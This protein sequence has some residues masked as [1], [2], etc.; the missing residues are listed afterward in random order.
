M[1]LRYILIIAVILFIQQNVQ[2]QRCS[3][4]TE[5]KCFWDGA[6]IPKELMCDG[7]IDCAK[8]EDETEW[9][10]GC[11][12]CSA[13]G[14]FHCHKESGQVCISRDYMCDDYSDCLH[15]E[16]E[17]YEFAKCPKKCKA[18]LEKAALVGRPSCRRKCRNNKDCKKKCKK[19]QDCSKIEKR[20]CVCDHECGMSCVSIYRTCPSLEMIPNLRHI[21]YV[22]RSRQ[23]NKLEDAVEPYEYDVRAYHTCEPGYLAVPSNVR[24]CHGRAREEN[25]TWTREIVC[26]R[27]CPKKKKDKVKEFKLSCGLDCLTD[28]DCAAGK[29]CQCDGPC[30]RTCVDLKIECGDAPPAENAFIEYTGEGFERVAHYICNEGTY[31]AA[32]DVSRKCTGSGK[33]GGKL[34]Q[35]E[36]VTCQDPVP[37][38]SKMG[39]RVLNYKHKTAYYYN[40]TLMFAC[41]HNQRLLGSEIRTCMGDGRWSGINTVCDNLGNLERCPHPGIPIGGYMKGFAGDYGFVVGGEVEFSCWDGLV[42]VGEK[43]QECL[44]I[45]EWSGDGAP[46]CVDPKYSDSPTDVINKLSQSTSNIRQTKKFSRSGRTIQLN[47]RGRI[48]VYFVID[49]SL[50][51]G[52]GALGNTMSFAKSLVKRLSQNDTT[53]RVNY[54]IIVFAT[55]PL[56]KLNIHDEPRKTA[57]EVIALLNEIEKDR[58][59]IKDDINQGTNIQLALD[60]LNQRMIAFSYEND[61]DKIIKRHCLVLTDGAKNAGESPSAAR[62]RIERG[63]ADNRPEFYSITSSAQE[64]SPEVRE[65]LEQ[66]ASKQKNFIYVEDFYKL[67]KYVNQITDVEEDYDSCGQAGDVGSV[68]KLASRGRVL[69]GDTAIERAWPWQA[70]VTSYDENI[71]AAFDQV[72]GGGS[73]INSKWVLSAA[74]VFEAYSGLDWEQGIMVS[75]GIIRRPHRYNMLE[76]SVKMFQPEKIYIHDEYEQYNGEHLLGSYQNDIALIKLGG[77]FVLSKDGKRLLMPDSLPGYVEFTPYIRPVCLPCS[78]D[79]CVS[80]VLMKKDSKGRVLIKGSETDEEKCKI[81]YDFL[82]GENS[83]SVVAVVATGFGYNATKKDEDE[84]Y[85]LKATR[86]LQQALLNVTK[87]KECER[88]V[89]VITR[90][91]SIPGFEHIFTEQMFCA[92][93]GGE[94][95]GKIIDT[96]KGDSGGPIVREIRDDSTKESCY[97]QLGIVSWGYG[98]GQQ[99]RIDRKQYFYPGF[100]TDVTSLMSWVTNKMKDHEK[101]ESD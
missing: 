67:H 41:G 21:R 72:M 36:R 73:L 75:L 52:A 76:G 71:L 87:R 47:S 10:A 91:K 86:E 55:T 94:E 58:E 100:Y 50:S 65:E 89:T 32:G 82:M 70:L 17:S 8:G 42:L 9:F 1:I 99:T 77:E 22:R 85:G 35:C 78:P 54:G 18:N 83:D 90:Q 23:T 101:K 38:I 81:E 43:K 26:A 69:G 27:S 74:H 88:A 37:A 95:R 20:K 56:I 5:F 11:T 92:V 84:D 34:I 25:K 60:L 19:G 57:E 15:E 40:A 66:I 30:G 31:T 61:E 28:G 48:E 79:S 46:D 97:V 3:E 6:C 96:C 51:V 68:R 80:Q 24:L 33:W 63:Y 2:G 14:K 16:D 64:S 49:L 29:T 7:K 45:K 53:G 98:C 44:F 62:K 4:F 59:N 13:I 93:G 39:G 12:N